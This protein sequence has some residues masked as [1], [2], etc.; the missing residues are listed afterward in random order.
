M[1]IAVVGMMTW[2]LAGE[3]IRSVIGGPNTKSTRSPFT[4]VTPGDPASE[5]SI[6]L[7]H[8]APDGLTASPDSHQYAALL[9]DLDWWG[10]PEF[11]EGHGFLADPYG[12]WRA[13][14]PYRHTDFVSPEVSIVNGERTT[15]TPPPCT[16]RRVTLWMYGG[17]TTLGLNQRN[18]HTIASELARV[19]H[20]QGL[21]LDVS[22]R[23]KLGHLHWLEAELFSLALTVESP[24]DIVLFYDGVNDSW[25]GSNLWELVPE[26]AALVDP[27]SVGLWDSRREPDP[28]IPAGPPGSRFLGRARIKSDELPR[29]A[30]LTMDHYNRSRSISRALAEQAGTVALYAWQPARI[31][32]DFVPEEPHSPT[33]F[34]NRNRLFDQLLAE[35]LDDDVIDLTD[36]LDG[37]REPLFTDDV[38]HNERGAR[39]IAEALFARV[40]PQLRESARGTRPVRVGP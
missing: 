39:L 16:C 40:E 38:H 25:G 34:E 14:N 1:L 31:S 32:R 18:D 17:S 11:R 19:A 12:S 7:K 20:E 10:S 37:T 24:P 15:W 21:W 22:N 30:R 9:G 2:S 5:P 13:V 27:T 3:Q 8:P 4:L 33:D 29:H 36:A 35:A 28:Q 23:G 26:V 6:V